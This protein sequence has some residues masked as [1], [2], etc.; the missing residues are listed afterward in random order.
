[1]LSF[2][3]QKKEELSKT[4]CPEEKTSV[5]SC[6]SL[7]FNMA[8]GRERRNTRGLPQHFPVKN[9]KLYSIYLSSTA[10]LAGPSC[11]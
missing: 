11:T 1:M 4:V 6:P 8:A 2:N 7:P 10:G 9:L 3:I 5:L